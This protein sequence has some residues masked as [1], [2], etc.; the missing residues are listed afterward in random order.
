MLRFILR[1]LLLTIPVLFGIVFVVFAI[2]RL[3]PGD[4]CRAMFGERATEELC[5]AFIQRFGLDRPIWDQF[6]IY[7]TDL[8][9]GDLGTS[10]VQGRPVTDL[11]IERFPVT[12]ELT[13]VALVLAT[14][15]GIGLGV[16]AAARRN[17]A[18]DV[19]TMV[20]ANI[21]ISTPIFVLALILIFVF[22]VVLKDT[23]FWFPPGQRMTPGMSVIPLA[24]SWGLTDLTG[25]LRTVVDLLSNMFVVNS[26]ITGQWEALGDALNH[27]VLPAVALATI[28]LSIIAR[29]TRSS[30]LDVMGQDYIRTARAKGLRENAVVM[31]HGLRNAIL[32]VVTVIGLSLGGLLAG[33]VLTESVF[34]LTGLGRTITEGV[35]GRDYT[36][37][38]GVTLVTALIYVLVNLAVDISYAFLDPRIRLQ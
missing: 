33:A 18:A 5:A 1:R 19:A 25:P 32:P 8:S 38:Q 28:P 27:L 13:L 26:L 14:T 10:I 31:R 15:L 6:I 37:V 22:S 3:L 20:V 35:L 17:S 11:L 34:G 24:E 7:L 4:P 30:L 36:V 9:H 29:M 16:I 2:A 23:P 21:G 12:L